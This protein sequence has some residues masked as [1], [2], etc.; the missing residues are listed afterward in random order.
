MFAHLR[1]TS[2]ISK[3]ALLNT[4]GQDGHLIRNFKD[5]N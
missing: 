1:E 4:V 2:S 5:I 3:L